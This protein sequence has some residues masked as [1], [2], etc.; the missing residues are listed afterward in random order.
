M[1]DAW[2]ETAE[3]GAGEMAIEL[4]EAQGPFW[5]LVDEVDE[6]SIRAIGAIGAT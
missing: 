3:T 2:L 5:L 1:K 6:N 4:A